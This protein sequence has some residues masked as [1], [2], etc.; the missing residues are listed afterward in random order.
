MVKLA[1]ISLHV[2]IVGSLLLLLAGA[3]LPRQSSLQCRATTGERFDGMLKRVLEVAEHQALQT[4]QSVG[5][6]DHPT[7]VLPNGKWQTQK[8]GK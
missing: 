7:S 2:V 4:I 1:A 5:S 8:A 6:E 3:P